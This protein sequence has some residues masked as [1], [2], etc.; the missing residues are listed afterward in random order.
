MRTHRLLQCLNDIDNNKTNTNI[1]ATL[2]NAEMKSLDDNGF[3]V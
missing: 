2:F 3:K 1:D